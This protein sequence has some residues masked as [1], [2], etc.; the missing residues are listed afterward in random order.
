MVPPVNRH[1]AYDLI[2]DG[3][4][5]HLVV[6][7]PETPDPDLRF[8]SRWAW[9]GSLSE[10]VYAIADDPAELPNAPLVSTD[11]RAAVMGHL[12]EAPSPG[13]KATIECGIP[14]R[15]PASSQGTWIELADPPPGARLTAPG[16]APLPARRFA[17]V[18][19][20][21]AEIGCSGVDRLSIAAS[22]DA[23]SPT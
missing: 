4:Y 13:W 5:A 6:I 23:G 19:S 2:H 1:F 20:G 17:F 10:H 18:A 22:W 11:R 7:G 14:A 9:I 12:A 8:M 3:P 15:V 16:L 21:I